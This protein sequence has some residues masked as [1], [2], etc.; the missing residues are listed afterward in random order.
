MRA[1]TVV[2]LLLIGLVSFAGLR[3]ADADP[4]KT[5][6]GQIKMSDKRFPQQ[7]KSPAAFVAKIKSMSKTSFYENKE[8]KSWKIYVIGFLKSPLND[9]EYLV[10]IYDVTGRQQQMLASFEQFTDERG[11]KTLT[12][13]I[14]LERKQFGVNRELMITM[15]SKGKVL[16][17][18]RFKILGEG[19]KFKGK[20]DFSKDDDEEGN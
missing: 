18:G 3:P 9:L 19:D 16:A 12:S 20:V 17:S 1:S 4:N 7:A 5:F 2:T 14:T 15:E 13:N 8:T 10:K 6:S 11:Q